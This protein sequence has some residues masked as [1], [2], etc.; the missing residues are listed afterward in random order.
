MDPDLTETRARLGRKN[1]DLDE[2]MKVAMENNED[3]VYI[4]IGSEAEMLIQRERE[5]DN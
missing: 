5:R 3:C 1:A 4:T 2:W